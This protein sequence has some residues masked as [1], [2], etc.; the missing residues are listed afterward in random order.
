MGVINITQR[1]ERLGNIGSTSMAHGA[2]NVDIGTVQH[3]RP[4]IYAPH[5]A[6]P[7]M[8]MGDAVG[9]GVRALGAVA[10]AVAA[11]IQR[12]EDRKVDDYANAMLDSMEKQGRDDSD[13]DDWN[14]PQRQH[15]QGQ[16]RGFYLRTGEGTKT[17]VDEWDKA[18]GDTFRKIGDSIGANDRVRE[19]TMDKLAT[20][21][22]ATV[23]R[24]ADHQAA[25]YRRMEMD[26]AKGNLASQIALWKNGRTEV[27]PDIFAQQERVDSLSLATPEKRKANREALALKLT[28]D[29]VGN[30]LDQCQSAE[31]FDKVEEA[32]KGGLKDTLPDM[33]AKNLPGGG[34]TVD[35]DMKD[36]ILSDIRRARQSFEIQRDREEREQMSEL[37]ALSDNALAYGGLDDLEAAHTDMT[38][39]AK[40]TPKGSRMET[41]ALQQAKRLGDAADGEARRLTW[42]AILEHAGDKTPWTPPKDSRMA[43]FYKP[44]KE[45]FDRQLAAYNA[46]GVMAQAASVTEERKANMAAMRASMMAAAATEPGTFHAKLTDAAEKGHITL[47]QYRK[48]RDEFN[49]VWTKE[50]MAQK[51]AALVDILKREFY[52]GADYDL[53]ERLSV[54]PKTGR[55]GYTKIP[56][57]KKGEVYEGEAFELAYGERTIESVPNP[58]LMSDFTPITP[59]RWT[60]RKPDTLTSDEQIKLLDWAMEL[61]QNDGAMISTDPQTGEKLDKPRKLNAATEFQAACS[62]LKMTK[63]VQSAQEMVQQRATALGLLKAGFA[64]D[65]DAVVGKATKRAAVE[66][67]ARGQLKA[68]KRR[69]FMPKMPSQQYGTPSPQ[70]GMRNDGK[71]YKG[72][73]FLGELK[74]PNG[75]V[76]TEYSIG[77][78]IDGEE[79]DIPTLVPTLTQDE[80]DL[81]V[82]DIIPHDKP[83]PEG[84]VQKAVDYA[85]WN[86]ENGRSVFANDGAQD[87]TED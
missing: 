5:M 4:G 73:G 27:L 6:R 28:A 86:I 61:A 78:N 75:K 76:A 67:N 19:R 20:Y 24:L 33:I 49:N 14:T 66:A 68:E 37:V 29:F 35:G 77:V 43:K 45:S 41:V 47:D 36:A 59:Q 8:M 7:G 50:G 60:E 44:L 32:V 81:M 26:S 79:I 48:L 58:Y 22:R 57:G 52:S 62:Q 42:D 18:F 10:G 83:I 70:Y 31:D 84:I 12:E 54:D 74:L 38:E 34:R 11:V 53:S 85:R 30:S 1:S 40:K 72:T 65:A 15:L 51:G 46:E 16:K 63:R 13:I 69:P 55:F 9:A 25:E 64:Q 56:G 21:R 23:S 2:T 17:L 87:G 3:H 80:I 39:R 71:T 82:N